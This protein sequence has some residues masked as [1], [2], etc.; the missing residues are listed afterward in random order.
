MKCTIQGCSGEYENKLIV[1]S[2]KRND[3][4]FVLDG[5]PAEVCTVC[6]DILIRPDTLSKVEKMIA[7]PHDPNDTV[8]L[9]KYA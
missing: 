6:G 9:Y 5:I 8:P 4:I 1:K 3:K 2:F 7:G